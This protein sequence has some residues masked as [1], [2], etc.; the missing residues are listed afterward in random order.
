MPRFEYELIGYQ[1]VRNKL[2][3]LA[4][5]LDKD[6]D[7]IVYQW[8]QQTR[9]RLRQRRYPPPRPRQR[10]RRTGRLANSWAVERIAASQIRILN[11]AQAPGGRGPYPT[12]VVGD[13]RRQGQAWMHRGRWWLARDVIEEEIPTLRRS[14]VS[15]IRRIWDGSL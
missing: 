2:R 12:Y 5:D 14:I 7:P 4:S 11:R 15:E 3:R 1:R 8:G 9:M 10:Y 6:L 13:F